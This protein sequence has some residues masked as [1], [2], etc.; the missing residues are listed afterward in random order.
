MARD[1]NCAPLELERFLAQADFDET[2][3]TGADATLF[4]LFGLI[5]S[6]ESDLPVAAVTGLVDGADTGLG[7]WLR[8]DPV[9]LRADL[10]RVLLLDARALSI[11][12]AEAQALAAEFNR[13][14]ETEGWRLQPLH[15]RRW[16]LRLPADPGMRTQPL[17]DA[18]R[19]DVRLPWGKA[20]PDCNRMLTEAQMLF[21]ESPVNRARESRGQLP[22]NSLW[23]WG[24][25]ELP[26]I[27]GNRWQGIYG[28]DPV[29]Q[30]LARLV[31]GAIRPPPSNAIDWCEGAEQETECLVVLE[32]TRYS[33][34]DKDLAGWS[35]RVDGL[36]RDWFAPCRAMLKKKVL[37][38]VCIYPCNG[39]VFSFQRR[40]PWRFRRRNRSLSRA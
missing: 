20:A 18:M 2:H 35:E 6:S 9:H 38:K 7:W 24:G 37:A 26:P 28:I 4:F 36:E 27:A 22:V 32:E 5:S 13:V 19:Q 10:R 21:F 12:M 11:G 14:F 3:V 33:A 16:Y 1:A 30:G 25:G 17:L 8:A 23:F 34:V 31:A 29:V 40:N 15:P 39:Q